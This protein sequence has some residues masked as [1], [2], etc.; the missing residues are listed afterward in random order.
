MASGPTTEPC[1]LCA[2]DILE[3]LWSIEVPTPAIEWSKDIFYNLQLDDLSGFISFA[4]DVIIHGER[5]WRIMG[6]RSHTA[7][8]PGR[9]GLL[10]PAASLLQVT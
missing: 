1:L 9:S 10:I 6:I 2:D 4:D 7:Y 5:R 8:M 3:M